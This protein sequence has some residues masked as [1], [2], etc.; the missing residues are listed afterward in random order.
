[1]RLTNRSPNTLGLLATTYAKLGRTV[2]ARVVLDD[3]LALAR[4]QYVPPASLFLVYQALGETETALDWLERSY[5]E[6]SNFMAYISNQP[7]DRIRG[8]N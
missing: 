2:E 3:M 7:C 8:F 6:R 4:Q 1:M 5:D